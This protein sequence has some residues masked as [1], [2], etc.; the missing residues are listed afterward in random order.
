MPDKYFSAFPIVTYSNTEVVDITVR[1]TM[2]DKVITNPYVFYPYEID[3]NER[4][5]QLSARYY[6]DQF[7]SWILYLSNKITDPYYEWYMNENE[8][9]EFI[10][11][12]Y[13]TYYSA[14]SKTKYYKNNWENDG[15]ITV[16]RY[17]SLTAGQQNY[18]EPL[19]GTSNKVIGYARKKIDWKTNTNKV[20][21]YTV[22]NT[23][24]IKDEICTVYFD[25]YNS[26]Q[27]QVVS[28]VTDT[29]NTANSLV[30][31]QHMSGSYYL[32]NTVQISN[33][34]SYVYGH[35]SNV[36][37][38][39]TGVLS[40]ANNLSDEEEN[41]W[42]PVTYLE[43]ETARNEYNKTINV[44]DSNLKDTMVDNLKDL[45]RS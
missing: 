39:F 1:T 14:Q 43:Y 20:V 45:L 13:G 3:S 4:A 34:I 32:S 29:S 23:N 24:F 22:S 38:L 44:L 40:S 7:K 27:G 16:S 17:D 11:K 10:T 6:E 18:Y 8:F 26:G 21:S 31:L 33:N 5:D 19:I 9:V 2:L 15:D 36:N 28:V 35:E 41:Y 37:T 42:V 12:K 25:Q 30:Y